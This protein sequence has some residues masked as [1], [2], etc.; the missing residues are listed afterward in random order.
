MENAKTADDRTEMIMEMERK[1]N[2]SWFARRSSNN[3][4]FC[5]LTTSNYWD[6]LVHIDVRPAHFL[7]TISADLSYTIIFAAKLKCQLLFRF[8]IGWLLDRVWGL[9]N[10]ATL[11][12]SIARVVLPICFVPIPR[13]C[14]LYGRDGPSPSFTDALVDVAS[15]RDSLYCHDHW[16]ASSIMVSRQQVLH[17]VDGLARTSWLLLAQ[18]AQRTLPSLV[19]FCEC[20][21]ALGRPQLARD[22]RIWQIYWNAPNPHS[23]R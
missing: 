22:E 11:L 23:F 9:E 8:F 21:I 7:V 4:R 1:L 3:D 15:A 13:L 17:W 16:C 14:R 6:W 2:P 20:P 5:R 12:L 10:E 18:D 19:A